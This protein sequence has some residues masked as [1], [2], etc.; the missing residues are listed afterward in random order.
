LSCAAF[1]N[2]VEANPGD[3]TMFLWAFGYMATLNTHL[4]SRVTWFDG[5][6]ANEQRQF[7]RSYCDEHPSSAYVEAVLALF[8]H[9]RQGQGIPAPVWDTQRR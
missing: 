5:M 6:P 8:D 2:T 1:S 9:V 7:I 3:E 4:E